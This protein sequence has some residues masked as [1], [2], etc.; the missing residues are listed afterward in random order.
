MDTNIN[1][2]RAKLELWK[3]TTDYKSVAAVLNILPDLFEKRI[4]SGEFDKSLLNGVEGDYYV[5][6]LYY[7]TK[8]W[9]NLLK[10][11]IG[12]WSFMFGPE[13]DDD[14]SEKRLLEFLQEE[15]ATRSRS[16][17]IIHNDQMKQVWK[18]HFDIDIDEL[19]I[20]FTKFDIHLEPNLSW[21]DVMDY[22]DS[23]PDGMAEWIFSSPVN[24]PS[25]DWVG[26]DAVSGLMEVV[27]Y[28]IKYER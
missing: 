25:E 22:F 13:E 17:A 20:D 15:N 4:E 27:A 11:T 12:S 9:D 6:P 14:Y 3:S 26:H 28:I 19:N 2:Y 1:D 16:E 21:S 5:V 10:G 18:K 8:A 7:V 23:C 24:H